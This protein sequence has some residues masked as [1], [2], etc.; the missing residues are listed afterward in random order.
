MSNFDNG[1][2]HIL[3]NVIYMKAM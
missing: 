1:I 3:K 2:T